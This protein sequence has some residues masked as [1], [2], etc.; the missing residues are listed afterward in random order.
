MSSPS[1]VDDDANSSPTESSPPIQ[2]PPLGLPDGTEAGQNSSPAHISLNYPTSTLSNAATALAPSASSSAISDDTTTLPS[3]LLSL[4]AEL[5]AHTLS[6]LPA[7]EIARICRP[8]CSELRDLIDCHENHIAVLKIKHKN[9][10]LQHHIN[11]LAHMEPHDLVSFISC[12]RFWVAQR[13]PANYLHKSSYD[14]FTNW[15]NNFDAVSKR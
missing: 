13:G 1:C 2:Q 11:T 15:S 5:L 6:F 4:L 14:S 8:V 10:G 12:F 3:G 9:A 7:R